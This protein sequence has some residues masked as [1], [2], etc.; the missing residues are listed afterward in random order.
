LRAAVGSAAEIDIGLQTNG[1]LL[2]RP[3]LKVFEEENIAV[4]LSLDGPKETNDRHR[5]T[6]RGKSSFAKTSTALNLLKEHPHIFSGIIA[7]ID[8]H[9]A[10]ETLFEFF[11]SHQRPKLDFHAGNQRRQRR[12]HLLHQ[13]LDSAAE[14]PQRSVDHLP[15]RQLRFAVTVPEALRPARVHVPVRVRLFFV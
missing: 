3:V 14:H 8:P 13:L 10:P 4:S 1:F 11:N 9:V 6:R 7:V 2:T 12:D 5:N 15:G